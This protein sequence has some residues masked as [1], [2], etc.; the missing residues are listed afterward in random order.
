[1]VAALKE[2]IFHVIGI[3]DLHLKR[4]P[5]HGYSP[6]D[7]GI[8]NDVFVKNPDG[9]VYVGVVWPGESVFPDF[10]LTR[11]R[12]WWGTLYKDFVGMGVAGFWNDMNEPALFDRPDKT[13]PLGPTHR[14]DHGPPLSPPAIPNL[15]NLPNH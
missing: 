5:D 8:K 2:Q 1:M 9:S 14:L 15:S 4:F 11:V 7:S 6:F 10:T 12:D 13:I 3:T